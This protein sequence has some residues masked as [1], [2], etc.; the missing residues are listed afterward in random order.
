M[1]PDPSSGP[2]CF[3]RREPLA[4]YLEQL[5]YVSSS[6]LRRFARTGVAP[7][8]P[9]P[10][11][12]VPKEATLGDALHA[13]LLE[14]ERFEDEFLSA[15]GSAPRASCLPEDE[16]MTQTWLSDATCKALR[17]MR[18]A[19]LRHP[20][21]P[22]GRWFDSGEKEL[23]IYWT[24][25]G[26]GR[27]KGRPDCFCEDV[28]LELKTTADARASRFAKSRQRFGYD[29]QAAHYVDAVRRLAGG[30]P[31]FLYVAVESTR[32]H[33]VWVHELPAEEIERLRGELDDIK[34]R[35]RAGTAAICSP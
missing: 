22:L 9:S 21:L 4:A 7:A 16:V 32:P 31:R 12:P 29:L 27:W 14:P 11:P 25:D 23:S 24:D 3:S 35:F 34:R 20:L 2:A 33:T 17:G 13:L 8:A 10:V 6:V 5:D 26:G 28:I 18:D 1:H 15:D 30:Y 19:V